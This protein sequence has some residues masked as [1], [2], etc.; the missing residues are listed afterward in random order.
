M[1]FF[2][3]GPLIPDTLLERCDTGRVVFLCGAGVSVPSQ[4]PSFTDLTQHVINFFDPPSDSEI[5]GAFRPWLEDQS[6][7]NVPLDQIFNLLHQEY[8]KDEVNA[9]VTARL[10]IVSAAE[11]VA[12]E[13]DLVKRISSSQSGAPQI[14]TTNFD[15][16]FEFRSK[17]TSL[18]IHEPPALPSIHFG[19]TI[20]GITYLHGRL[21]GKR[22][23][24]PVA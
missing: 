8:G 19:S 11:N 5:M 15:R 22:Q 17:K 20:E 2:A 21:V 3:N 13:H 10:N 12:R 9:L 14:V 1:R 18:A 24:D 7:A 16:L 6:E 23:G 4:M